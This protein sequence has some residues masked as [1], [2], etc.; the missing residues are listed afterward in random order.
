F[1]KAF[2]ANPNPSTITAFTD[3]R[4]VDANAAF[5]EFFGYPRESLIGHLAM[6][7][8]LWPREEDRDRMVQGVK[9]HG[10][11]RNLEIMVN[12]GRG[13]KR[14]LLFSG[15]TL[16]LK[17]QTCL[18]AI[19][20]D[21]TDVRK[22]E[23]ERQRNAKLESVGIL[24]GGIAHDFNNILTGIVGNV[25]L[26]GRLIGATSPAADLLEEA[27]KA[28]LRAKDLTGQLLTFSRGGE[29]VRELAS[30]AEAITDSATFALRGAKVKCR[31]ALPDD[32]WAAEIDVGQIS[33][34]I[35]NMVINADEAMP[36]GGTVSIGARNLVLG[37][38]GTLPLANG[39]YV[40]I[41]IADP[42]IGIPETLL[43]KIFDPYFTTKQRGSGL[44]LATAYSIIKK[45]GG[46]IT[47]QSNVGVGTMFHIYLPASEKQLPVRRAEAPREAPVTRKARILVM[48]DEEMIRKMLARIL[49][50]AG[51]EV[52]AASDGAAAVEHYV[53]ARE[54]GQPFDAV[55]LDLTVP[56]GMGGRETLRGLLEV[57]PNVKAVVSSGYSNDV[58]M[59]NYREYGFAAVVAK[60]YS[61]EALGAT[62]EHVLRGA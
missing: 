24:A 22:L 12:N 55:I 14:T 46:H 20:V 52:E 28:C 38:P 23:E 31:F 41:T 42:G 47:V 48:D 8:A 13:E 15:E 4:I 53:K 44:G 16:L 18:L 6:E 58:I 50:A 33:Q 11:V 32:L 59:S 19:A 43:P 34:V 3:G 29:P 10:R 54:S 2:H 5:T 26:A 40:E 45:H 1:S 62:L 21:V 30:I 51:Y 60:P 37:E 39:R 7:L 56:G 25:S 17:G 49:T 9:E 57:D 27:E 36:Q 35:S 61:I